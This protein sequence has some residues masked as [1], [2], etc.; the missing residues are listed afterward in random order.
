MLLLCY[1]EVWAGISS[2]GEDILYAV[3]I[4]ILTLAAA[5][6]YHFLWSNFTRLLKKGWTGLTK[7]LQK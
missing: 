5:A 3:V 6:V 7:K 2:L 4:F 1:F